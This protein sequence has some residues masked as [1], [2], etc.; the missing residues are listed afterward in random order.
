M[1]Q[2]IYL[3]FTRFG[4]VRVCKKRAPAL[5]QSERLVTLNVEIPDAVFAM[6]AMVATVQVPESAV[7][8]PPIQV[9]AVTP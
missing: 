5:R 1:R 8:V 4:L 7:T 6:P 2:R 3:V 9:Q